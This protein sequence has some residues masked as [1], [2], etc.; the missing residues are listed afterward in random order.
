MKKITVLFFLFSS[1]FMIGQRSGGPIK[2]KGGGE[3]TGKVID[4]ETQKAMEYVTVALFKEKDSSLV[5][6]QITDT[7]GEFYLKELPLGK[8]YLRFSF[9]GYKN[10]FKRNILLG[11]NQLN[12]DFNKVILSPDQEVLEDVEVI[13]DRP[14]IVYEIDKKV[15]NVEDMNTVASA[16]AIEVLENIPSITVDM[17]GNVS[18]RGSAGFTLL[19]DNKPSPLEAS[20]ALQLIPASNIKDIEIITNPSAKYNAEGTSG[21]INVILKK[22][23][24]EGISTLINLNGATF[25]N[26]G[27]DF[28]VSVNKN[29]IK[30]NVGGNFRNRNRYRDITQERIITYDENISQVNS[31][32]LHRFFS[33]NYGINAALEWSP[34][35]KN[36]FS[37]GVNGNQRQFNAAANYDF[38]EYSNNML[39]NKYT[40]KERTL[41]QFFGATASAGYEHLIGGDKEH[42]VN[43]TAVYNLHDGDE[44]ALTESFDENEL[45]VQGNQSTE[46]GP[47]QMYRV[48]VDYEK[49]LKGKAKFKLG[50]R[51]D[52]GN[53]K[54]DQDSYELNTSTGEYV[55]LPLFSTDVDYIQNVYAGYA[56]YSGEYQSKLGYQFGLRSEYTDRNIYMETL[57]SNTDIERL[58]WFPSAHF[59][60]KLN[61]KDQLKANFSRRIQRPRSWNLEPFISWEDPYTV[62][63][64][65][66]DLLPEYIQSYELGWIKNLK[67]GSFSLELY[68]RNTIN[69]IERIQ[70]AYDSTVIIKRPVNAGISN[71]L[72]LELSYRKR[73]LKWW[74][75]D[76]GVN[77]FYYQISGVLSNETF[78]RESFSYNLRLSNT[79]NLKKDWKVQAISRYTSAI[80]TAQ[81]RTNGFFTLDLAVKK[82]FW[83]NRLS[84]ALQ[85]RNALNSMRR[86]TWVE[87]AAL[88]SYRL[89]E[90]RWPEIALS[91]AL[92]LNNY[93]HQDK[94]KTVKG[95]EF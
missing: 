38:L 52:F 28:L 74:G 89:A 21:I 24:L 7:K 82:D 9:I 93:N 6:G 95:E 17:D 46:V 81:G 18:L 39:T 84:G 68:Y 54:D 12:I 61:K 41:R 79:F 90:P 4:S 49:P 25:N 40:N 88:Y 42:R 64:G 62:R 10:T 15:V 44:D 78:E 5:T 33:T 34:N 13:V 36:S 30:L 32:G 75:V 11:P 2:G 91:I 26:Y 76:L 53:N 80:A 27:G 85:F 69:T 94:I 37:L 71:S 48:N 50:L 29:K 86:E 1:L 57:N 19:I 8:Y 77:S 59:S 56:I 92:R 22:N 20:E 55:K 43:V 67:K 63:Q 72:G 31:E 16:T 35:R 47:S 73:L 83:Q 65:N 66:P 3:I 14:Q 23:K 51:S 58:D 87:T 70:E 60:Y 45:R